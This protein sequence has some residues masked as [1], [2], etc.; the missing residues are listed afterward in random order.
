MIRIFLREHFLSLS[1]KPVNGKSREIGK[2]KAKSSSVKLNYPWYPELY[3]LA[4]LL[5]TGFSI[6]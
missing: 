4:V 2:L 6:D 1:K 3:A 5:A